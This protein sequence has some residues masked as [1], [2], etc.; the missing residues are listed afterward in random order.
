MDYSP[1]KLNSYVYPPWANGV[2][3]GLVLFSFA[4]IPALMIVALV[5]EYKANG[6][7]TVFMKFDRA[8]KKIVVFRYPDPPYFFA[9]TLKFFKTFGSSFTMIYY[10]NE[11]LG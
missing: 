4:F 2:G 9:P 7:S 5:K 1:L 10:N 6:V 11:I 3:W 8:K